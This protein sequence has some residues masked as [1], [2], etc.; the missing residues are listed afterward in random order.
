[1]PLFKIDELSPFPCRP[2]DKFEAALLVE[3]P[4]APT[5]RAHMDAAMGAHVRGRGADGRGFDGHDRGCGAHDR[6][7]V[8]RTSYLPGR[9]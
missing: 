1:M 6:V 4:P 2:A 8:L 7:Q 9:D 3:V 5:G